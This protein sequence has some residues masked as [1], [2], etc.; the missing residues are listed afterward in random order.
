MLDPLRPAAILRVMRN[1]VVETSRGTVVFRYGGWSEKPIAVMFHGFLRSADDLAAWS[2]RLPDHN[3]LFAVLPWH[4]APDVEGGLPG[5][6]DAFAEAFR[7]FPSAADL[8]VGESLGALIALGT[9]GRRVV[10]VDPFLTTAK[11]WP[12]HVMVRDRR[13]ANPQA[14]RS[15]EAIFDR[16]DHRF[17]LD[18]IR[19]PTLVIGGD[20][21]LMPPRFMPAP[22]S[23]LDEEDF[24]AFA[25]HP[26]VTALRISGGHALL[27]QAPDLCREMILTHAGAPRP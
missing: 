19:S 18:R 23:L 26:L 15:Y 12:V 11:L 1:L 27:H 10:A 8:V 5:Y 9:P 14:A 25:A 21:P 16:K 17:I 2:E 3:L 20:E 7:G 13:K 24:A 6:V 4:N 22:P